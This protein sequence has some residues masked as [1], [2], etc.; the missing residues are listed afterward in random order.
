MKKK[1][2]VYQYLFIFLTIFLSCFLAQTVFGQEE[3]DDVLTTVNE[4]VRQYKLGEFAGAISNLDYA[5][6]LIR[7]KR[8]ERMKGLLP[9]PLS[10]WQ[11][12]PAEAQALG[13][14]VF[15]GG[16]TVS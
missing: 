6:Q 9:E 15:G 7:Q 14:A 11:A 13:T 3:P 1:Q 8:S 10:G 12:K 5:T 4:A 16:I 2:A